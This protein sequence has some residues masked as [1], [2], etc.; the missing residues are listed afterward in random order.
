MDLPPPPLT[1][2]FERHCSDGPRAEDWDTV[3][4]DL[5]HK[6]VLHPRCLNAYPDA[7][8]IIRDS[9]FDRYFITCS[10][11]TVSKIPGNTFIAYHVCYHSF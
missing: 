9:G 11:K 6:P 5:L 8:D 10:E 4:L 3:S 7:G 2:L 1:V